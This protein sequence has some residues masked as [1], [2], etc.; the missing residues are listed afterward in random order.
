M[1]GGVTAVSPAPAG[2][3]NPSREDFPHSRFQKK[4]SGNGGKKFLPRS[5]L[6]I[7]DRCSCGLWWESNLQFNIMSFC[8]LKMHT[9]LMN[10]PCTDCRSPFV[11]FISAHCNTTFSLRLVIGGKAFAV[12]RTGPDTELSEC[13]SIRKGE[14]SSESDRFC[15]TDRV[16]LAKEVLQSI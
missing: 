13:I 12:H 7:P 3:T 14:P 5:W 4:I 11:C 1:G 2:F 15:G 6:V 8:V 16:R 9:L 10:V